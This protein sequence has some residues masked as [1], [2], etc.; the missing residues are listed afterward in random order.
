MIVLLYENTLIFFR[1]ISPNRP[2][3]ILLNNLILTLIQMN[4]FKS[5]P[6]INLEITIFDRTLHT[7]TNYNTLYH[8]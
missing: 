6:I 1:L 8:H 4:A 7:K 5:L 2:F 3:R